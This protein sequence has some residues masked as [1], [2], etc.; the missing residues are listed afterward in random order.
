MTTTVIFASVH[1][2]GRSQMAAA[3]FNRWADPAKARAISAGTRPAE[4]V[5]PEVVD[6]LRERGIDIV[7]VKPQQLTDELARRAQRLVTMGC[8][9][10]CPVVPGLAR[11]DWP[12]EDPKG[13]ARERVRE[14]CDHIAQRVRSLLTSEGWIR[15]PTLT[16][17]GAAEHREQIAA[18]LAAAKL[19]HED[20][21]AH[22][23]DFLVA[24]DGA[25]VVGV[26]GLERLGAAGCSARSPSRRSGA[27]AASA[28]S[29]TRVS[30]AAASSSGSASC[31]S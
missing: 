25:R 26:V 13:Q 17:A 31:T 1:N 2:A 16:F 23:A 24:V 5:H 8:G 18:L 22:L 12:H 15:E 4:R 27:A 28:P 10:E 21:D 11:D 7:H 19:P 14:I 9:D 29:S 6:V 20:I 30:S 3:L